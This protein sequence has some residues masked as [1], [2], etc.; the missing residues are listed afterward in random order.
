[1]IESLLNELN[2]SK[3]FYFNNP[4]ID[5]ILYSIVDGKIDYTCNKLELLARYPMVVADFSTEHWGSNS[6][7]VDT[8]RELLTNANIN[9]I[10]LTH[11]PEDHQRYPEVFF[12]P[13]WYHWSRKFLV[14]PTTQPT[15]QR[16]YL[17]GCFNGNPRPH[18]IINYLEMAR[19]SYFTQ[20][21][22]TLFNISDSKLPITNEGITLTHEQQVAW[23]SVRKQLPYQNGPGGYF[24]QGENMNHP[25]C[26]DSY[27]HFVTE[28]N[29]SSNVFITE[30]TWKPIA[31]G[32]LFL[33]LSNPGTVE[34]LRNQGVDC[35]DDIIDH[36]YYDCEL[37][38]SVRMYKIQSII[39]SLVQ[40]DLAEIY[41]QT[42]N[43][44]K[45]NQ[46][47]YTDGVFDTNY[48]SSI[49]SFICTSMP[50]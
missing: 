39:D 33:L 4:D 7:I 35:F 27:I 19:K 15:Q 40:Q 45:V 49:R 43:R 8:A 24:G 25:I 47:N 20:S 26:T 5:G 17:V 41:C 1:V 13:H 6:W 42:E 12:Y 34:Y 14:C 44:R 10:I 48:Y 9:F 38:W 28:S 21:L 18:R 31:S 3:F 2:S 32:Q 50:N 29:V 16:Q 36:K 23:D 46:K 11:N 22:F 37:D 30:K